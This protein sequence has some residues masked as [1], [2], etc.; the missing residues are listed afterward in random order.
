MSIQRC[1][2]KCKQ[3]KPI[4]EF[5][6]NKIKKYGR[7]CV[8]KLCANLAGKIR[9]EANPNKYR[10]KDIDRYWNNKKRRAQSLESAKRSYR[11]KYDNGTIHKRDPQREMASRVLRYHV[12][13]GLI[14]KPDKCEQCSRRCRKRLIHGHHSDYNKPLDVRWLCWLCH[15]KLHRKTS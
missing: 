1:C 10:A 4:E 12:R 11:V 8:C 2:S 15:H 5:R 6:K 3:C 13:N 9:R 14:Q 7:S